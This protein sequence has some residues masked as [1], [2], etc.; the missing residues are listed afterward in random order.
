MKSRPVQKTKDIRAD[1]A[2]L[3]LLALCFIVF[4]LHNIV[5]YDIWWQLKTGQLVRES[6]WPAT[7]PFSYGFPGR[8]WIEI[9]WL[10]CVVISLIYEHLGLNF[11]IV[12]KVLWLLCAGAVFWLVGRGKAL[13]AVNFGILCAIVTMHQR[14]VIRPELVT[15]AFLAVTLLCLRRFQVNKDRRWLYVLPVLQILWTNS[16]TLYV[17]GP[18]VMWIF[19][20]A[21]WMGTLV[22]SAF[23]DSPERIKGKD[24]QLLA[25][26]AA[27]S[28][29]ACFLNPYGVNGALFAV[30][31][32]TE[33]QS[34]NV[35]GGIITEFR[36]PLAVPGWTL[37]FVGYIA[38]I[39]ISAAGFLLRRSE[40][41]PSWLMLWTAFLYLSI[42]AER[43]LPLFGIV[44]AVTVMLNYGALAVPNRIRWASRIGCAL[45]TV[46]MIP[47]V[48]GNYYY[49][50]VDPDRRFGFGVAERRFPI[51]AM[52]FVQSEN[53]PRPVLTTL[54]ESAFMLF[55]G[56]PKSVYIDGRLEVYGGDNVEEAMKL[57]GTGEN[58]D[59]TA[60]RLNIFTAVANH[61]KDFSFTR[62]F[63]Q[64]RSWASV[65]YDDSHV[66]FLRIAPNTQSLID[67]LRINWLDPQ[68]RKVAVDPKLSPPNWLGG[69]FP[70]ISENARSRG[71]GNLF[72][73]VNVEK[74]QEYLEEAVRIAPDDYRSSLQLGVLYRGQKRE[75]EAAALIARVP[76]EMW[77]QREAQIFAGMM[78][79]SYDNPSAAVGAWL[80]V[81]N[82]GER[83]KETF[84]RLA[85]VAIVTQ[86]WEI[87]YNALTELSTMSPNDIQIWN[88]MG[89]VADKMKRPK[90]ALLAFDKSLQLSPNQ[91]QV[92]TQSGVILLELGDAKNAKVYFER[93]LAVEPT[94]EPAR[95]QL[96]RL[97]K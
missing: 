93:A 41:S 43:N 7:D 47:A 42:L 89:I 58:L 30:E 57:L 68:E 55:E 92:L 31:L 37:L 4:A 2:V 39:V 12:A 80:E 59:E 85:R 87:A 6:G 66:V 82:L 71:L 52:A 78:Y 64:N 10:Y 83:S 62:A 88:N 38:V 94:F 14:L 73:N 65:Y 9:R 32:F 63:L 3:I 27:A 81:I 74:A 15:F 61:E 56:G 1:R 22:P 91:P 76:P 67:R 24:W 95:Q 46:V 53:L 86:R 20:A 96:E 21:E 84:E 5:A 8:V 18:V 28:T 54:G 26:A 72:L 36:S 33:I 11:L 44:A 16:H 34:N 69:V 49:R 40:M 79:E 17:L 60:G 25:M 13:W 97:P 19:V 51:R 75:S 23:P 77:R 29:L 50:S 70:G 45:F 48:A 90:D 35:L